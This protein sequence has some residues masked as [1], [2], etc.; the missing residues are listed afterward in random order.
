MSSPIQ[1]FVAEAIGTFA[2]VFIGAGVV[3]VESHT[4]PSHM[5]VTGG[6]VGLLGVALAHGTILTA[7]IYAVGSVSGGHFNPAVSFAAWLQRRLDA[8]L[9]AGYVVAQLAAA[10]AAGLC[11]A[12]LFPDEVALS[13]LGTPYLAPRITPLRGILLEGVITFLLVTAILLG[14]RKEGGA[15]PLA[16]LAIGATLVA[17]ILF[18]GPLTGAG[19]NPARYL[20]PALVS[21]RLSELLVYV[22]GPLAGACAAA[23]LTGLIVRGE[24]G[25]EPEAAPDELETS[26]EP[27]GAPTSSRRSPWRDASA[28]RAERRTTE[29]PPQGPP[30]ARLRRAYELFEAGQLQTAARLVEPLLSEQEFSQRARA[31][32]I[33]IEGDLA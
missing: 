18:A 19:A 8:N 9:F 22:A 5:D 24:A 6:K 17:L 16:G 1:K 23:L 25:E 15:G 11:L 31:L 12:L 28:P 4:G 21:G 13:G 14:T 30:E 7:M 20:G 2:L 33:V 10:V 27:R 29:R 26:G 32:L 3:I